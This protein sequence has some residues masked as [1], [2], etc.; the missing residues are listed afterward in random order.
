MEYLFPAGDNKVYDIGIEEIKRMHRVGLRDK[1]DGERMTAG[2]YRGEHFWDKGVD[3]HTAMDMEFLRRDPLTAGFRM[4]YPHGLIVQQSARTSYFRGENQQ[5]GYSV[6]SLVRKLRQFASRKDRELYRLI[7][8]MRVA[9]FR[10]LLQSFEHVKNW[11]YGTVL[12]EHLA[13]HYGLDTCWLD[14][15]NDF[16]VALFFATCY[17]DHEKWMWKPLTKAMIE[18]D[19]KSRYG[20]IFHIPSDRANSRWSMNLRFFQTSSDE[21]VESNENVTR[22][23]VYT[24]PEYQGTMENLIYPIGFQPF[25]RCHMQSGYA[26]YMREANPLEQDGMFQKLRFRQSE[27][28][29]RKV[30]DYMD[31]GEKIYPHEGLGKADFIIQSIK[32]ATEFSYQA[33][34]E[35][36]YRNHYYRIADREQ[37]LK[38]LEGFS[39]E[40]QQFRVGNTRPWRLSS[41]RRKKIDSMYSGFTIEEAYGVSVSEWKCYPKG[42]TMFEP[43]MVMT[44]K[45]EPGVVDMRSRELS[46]CSNLFMMDALRLLHTVQYQKM[47]DF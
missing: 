20:M 4:E 8:D 6:P 10:M 12:Y 34:E 47:P 27:E 30:Y 35:A 37:C 24:H 29:S 1:R 23:R 13:Q 44:D 26:I 5:H 14:V 17:F 3:D 43:W 7:A 41:G 28:L 33:F 31:G 46:D 36:L 32:N 11:K 21:I 42:Y 39:Y 16:D 2:T 19:E 9:E 45:E 40:G 38:D 15:T 25:M 22:Y 18:A